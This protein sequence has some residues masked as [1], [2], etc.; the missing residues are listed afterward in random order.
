MATAYQGPAP[1][2]HAWP[3][4]GQHLWTK[5]ENATGLPNPTQYRKC[6]HPDCT[7][8]EYRDAPRA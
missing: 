8:V 5:W 4:P 3:L 2:E 1:V 6:I 7:K